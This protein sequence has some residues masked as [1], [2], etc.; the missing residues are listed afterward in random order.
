MEQT[1]FYRKLHELNEQVASMSARRQ[2]PATSG[3]PQPARQ[4]TPPLRDPFLD[5]INDVQTHIAHLDERLRSTRGVGLETYPALQPEWT[6]HAAPLCQGPLPGISSFD[7]SAPTRQQTP[8]LTEHEPSNSE[9]ALMLTIIHGAMES[10]LRAITSDLSGIEERLDR[11]EPTRFTPPCS[12]M[13]E[14]YLT[15]LF[16][17][18]S[19]RA[20]PAPEAADP[21]PRDTQ[22]LLTSSSIG[23]GSAADLTL[24]VKADVARSAIA[25]LGFCTKHM[26]EMST[27][28]DISDAK[29]LI[30]DAFRFSRQVMDFSDMTLP[31]TLPLLGKLEQS[32]KP[33]G[34]GE[35]VLNG[36]LATELGNGCETHEPVSSAC[37]PQREHYRDHTYAANKCKSRAET[38]DTAPEG[39][40]FRDQELNRMDELLKNSQEHLRDAQEALARQAS[41]LRELQEAADENDHRAHE[42]REAYYELR[43][44]SESQAA[45]VQ[46]FCEQKDAV[47]HEQ[48]QIMARGARLLEQRDSEIDALGHRL[49]ATED[50]R[51]HEKRQV[52]RTVRLLDDMKARQAAMRDEIAFAC[53]IPVRSPRRPNGELRDPDR[54]LALAKSRIARCA[55]VFGVPTPS[56]YDLDETVLPNGV[57][58]VRAVLKADRRNIHKLWNEPGEFEAFSFPVY[59]IMMAFAYRKR[60]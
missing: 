2:T 6:P 25:T 54:Q 37:S 5:Q 55:E 43:S 40:A 51:D 13:S 31:T 10:R 41:Q 22:N 58:A 48:E 59:V 56:E 26:A 60:Q 53:A 34:L 38:F 50:D 27:R 28:L 20:A 16:H 32:Q 8:L 1:T 46:E 4:L 14:R 30:Q 42:W 9:I 21:V 11:L 49:R 29:E 44:S 45:S 57:K 24:Q 36:L 18:S 33:A 47:I 7:D 39:I 19:D 35:S 12:D 15:P 52:A 23:H 17:A 3:L